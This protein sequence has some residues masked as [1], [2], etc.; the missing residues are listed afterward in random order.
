MEGELQLRANDLPRAHVLLQ[1]APCQLTDSQRGE[2]LGQLCGERI[3]QRRL[4]IAPA[5]RP[6]PCRLCPLVSEKRLDLVLVQKVR[7]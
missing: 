7:L 2:R 3:G 6:R 5:G 1:D 4:R